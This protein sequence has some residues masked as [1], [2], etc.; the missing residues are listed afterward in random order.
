[1]QGGGM[2]GAYSAATIQP[3]VDAGVHEAFDHVVGSS[4]GAIN[5]AYLMSGDRNTYHTYTD[6]LTNKHFVNPLRLSRIVDIDFLVDYALKDGRT[7]NKT[8]LRNS[9]SRLHTVI[10][11]AK[12][13]EQEVLS[14]YGDFED[15]YEVFRATSALP[16]L[17]N[18]TVNLNGQEYMDGGLVN[19]LPI[20]VALELGC[21]DLIVVLT[22]HPDAY[23]FDKP[24]FRLLRILSW[25]FGRKYPQSIRDL[26]PVNE[27]VLR[28]NL[29]L[30]RNHPEEVN[31][32]ILTP[33]DPSKLV[34]TT[35]TSKTKAD[36]MAA[37]GIEDMKNFLER[38][39]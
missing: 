7:I 37:M 35:S 6:D 2:R 24:F 31:M 12:T 26:L 21:T 22:E 36:D 13:G 10:T 15:I 33:S 23:D 38:D 4:A 3:L 29:D 28:R 25:L 32:Y 27:T 8:A 30:L 34:F 16:L 18:K 19:L 11:N 14:E 20:D 5:G 39:F 9:P 1:M 17:Y